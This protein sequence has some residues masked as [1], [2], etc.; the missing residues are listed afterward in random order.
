[1]HQGPNSNER[2]GYDGTSKART[3]DP[4]AKRRLGQKVSHGKTKSPVLCHI[5]RGGDLRL[6]LPR[7]SVHCCEIS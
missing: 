4:E 5:S 7:P 6:H 1:M 2:Y 3:C